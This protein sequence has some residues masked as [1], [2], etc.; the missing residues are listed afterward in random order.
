MGTLI[1]VEWHVCCKCQ[2]I[3]ESECLK[4]PWRSSSQTLFFKLNFLVQGFS[5]GIT[6][7]IIISRNG[8]WLQRASCLFTCLS[9]L[10]DHSSC[11][12]TSTAILGRNPCSLAW[13]PAL[14]IWAVAS[15]Q[16]HLASY[17]S[18]FSTSNL[19]HKSS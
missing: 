15:L 18:L 14:M 7:D 5:Q 12:F 4:K 2:R 13:D 6:H 3:M 9:D 16:P 11:S 17:P 8:W 1:E 19:L 10:G